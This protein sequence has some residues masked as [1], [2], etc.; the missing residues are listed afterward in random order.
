MIKDLAHNANGGK[1][2]NVISLKD[3]LFRH[4]RGAFWG[5]EYAY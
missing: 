2:N 1:T 3:Y 4:N 5:G